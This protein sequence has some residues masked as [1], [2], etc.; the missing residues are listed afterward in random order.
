MIWFTLFWNFDEKNRYGAC[1][2]CGLKDFMVTLKSWYVCMYIFIPSNI[3]P[4]W[5]WDNTKHGRKSWGNPFP[6]GLQLQREEGAELNKVIWSL[7][8]LIYN[9][10]AVIAVK[11]FEARTTLVETVF[12][13]IRKFDVPQTFFAWCASENKVPPWIWS[14]KTILKLLRNQLL[15]LLNNVFSAF[16]S[17]CFRSSKKWHREM[18]LLCSV[19]HSLGE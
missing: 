15:L 14:N 1:F 10:D 12:F 2:L 16:A 3:S 4:I 9:P 5:R 18:R 11:L 19:L 13:S 17:V 7:Q 8:R 6:I